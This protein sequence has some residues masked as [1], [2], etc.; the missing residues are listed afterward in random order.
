M[1]YQSERDTVGRQAFTRVEIDMPVCSLAYGVAPCTASGPAG[2]QCNNTRNTCQDTA[3][4]AGGT[5]VST[6]VL[7]DHNVAIPGVPMRPLIIRKRFSPTLIDKK[8]SLGRRAKIQ[9]Q[10][11]DYPSNDRGIDPYWATRTYVAEDQGTFW[12]KVK[13]IY[14]Y[15]S[16][17]P[18]RVITG[19]IGDV[20]NP[21][22]SI[23]RHY[24]LDE[25]NGPKKG[26]ITLTG[27][28]V[29]KLAD[30]K[31][32]LCPRVTTGTL[33]NDINSTTMASFTLTGGAGQY[34]TGGGKIRIEDEIIQYT[35]GSVSG[36]NFVVAG[37]ITRS[38]NNTVSEDHAA[39]ST[40]QLCKEVNANVVDFVYELLTSYGNVQVSYI[41]LADWIAE[42]DVWLTGS[43][44]TQIITKPTGVTSLIE[45]LAEAFLFKVWRAEINQK[46]RFK[47]V[48]PFNKVTTTWTDNSHVID[49]GVDVTEQTDERISRVIVYY[50][51]RNPIDH[52]K[53][54]HFRSAYMFVGAD[55]ESSDQYGDIRLKTIF[56]RFIP[57]DG[58]AVR[59]GSRTY[60]IYKEV[61]KTYKLTIDAKD[62]NVVTGDGVN[63]LVHEIQNVDGSTQA[64]LMQ[65]MSAEEIEVG[66]RYRYTLADTT[67]QGRYARIMSSGA[68]S[69]YSSASSAEKETGGYIAAAGGADFSVNEPAYKIL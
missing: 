21:S 4:Y 55:A 1:S 33:A 35:A 27:L 43:V 38:V 34:P 20:Y 58:L 16:G 54:E 49:G 14:R 26:V 68:T 39:G 29:L 53:P 25:I 36:D 12:G 60:A 41:T 7:C 10:C 22:E 31:R 15:Y 59:C 40:A 37:T 65:V 62:T 61:P 32:A 46:V 17:A 66:H 13:A 57:S 23:T 30:D 67:F 9:I 2:G 18:M 5:A 11:R 63:L 47:A 3:N 42:R 44:V 50:N 69:V 45:E 56:A 52:D 8:K 51:P 19:Y 64:T 6:I 48:S 24:I 28:D